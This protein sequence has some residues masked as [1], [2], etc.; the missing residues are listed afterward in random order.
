[1]I[2]GETFED[3]AALMEKARR[4]QEEEW[5][6]FQR[7]QSH[8]DTTLYQQLQHEDSD[9]RMCSVEECVLYRR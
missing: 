9:G 4:E 5:M 7:L 3:D 6:L 8:N 1:M 2:G